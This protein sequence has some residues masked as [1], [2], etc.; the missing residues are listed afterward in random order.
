MRKRYLIVGILVVIAIIAL[1][2]TLGTGAFFTS[3]AQVQN[4]TLASGTLKVQINSEGGT[5]IPLNVQNLEPGVW[6][7][8]GQ[9]YELGMYNTG[10]STIPCKYR[11]TFQNLVDANGL[12]SKINVRVRHTFAGSPNPAAWPIVWQGS[13]SS[14]DM[15]ST[16]P[17]MG[18]IVGGGIL[19]V[20]ITHV[21]VFEFQLDTTADN[22]FQNL[23]ATFSLQMDG[24]QV[25]DP[26]F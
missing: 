15:K 4:N 22:S 5:A 7:P 20:N 3:T 19:G 6:L 10:L 8:I 12:T 13:F 18:T 24:Y 16:A 23:T 9:V 21:Y 17:Q 1:V 11:M 14:F 25:A 26:I 2:G